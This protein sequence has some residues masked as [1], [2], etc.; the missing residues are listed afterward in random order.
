MAMT[1]T[2]W[3]Q[4]EELYHST[5]ECEPGA[6]E[7]FLVEACQGDEELQREVESLRGKGC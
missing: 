4:V 7:A 2:R 5:Q 6:R 1:P 3:Q